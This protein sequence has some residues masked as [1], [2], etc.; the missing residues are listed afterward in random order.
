MNDYLVNIAE[1]G[2][3]KVSTV[4]K[5]P[6]R[7][8]VSCIL[9]GIFIGFGLGL[10]SKIGMALYDAQRP[11]V[12]FMPALLFSV[13][14]VFIV[15][16]K[17]E[18]FT[19]NCMYMTVAFL[20]KKIS[21][22]QGLLILFVVYIGNF[23]GGMIFS[24]SMM[25]VHAFEGNEYLLELA[26]HKMEASFMEILV[27]GIYCNFLVSLGVFFTFT[28]KNDVAKITLIILSVLVFFMLG[29]DHSIAN[30]PLLHQGIVLSH[31]S[32]TVGD[33]IH[34]LIPATIGNFI[35][36]G[37][38]VGGLLYFIHREK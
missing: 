30:M 6:L 4:T 22:T 20:E 31:G 17:T 11:M 37:L 29:F 9:A 38:G 35:G 36:G 32:L 28:T 26:K 25:Y 23:I 5:Q 2:S 12:V 14:L 1:A 24:Y 15:F 27:K 3:K 19:S 13:A 33:M 21:I 7:Y 18:L 34:N 8:L 16:T 10:A